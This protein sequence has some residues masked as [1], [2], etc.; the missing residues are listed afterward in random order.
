[1]TLKTMSPNPTP[2]PIKF[3]VARLEEALAQ[4][5]PDALPEIL[6]E[7]ERV[8]AGL[9]IRMLSGT[10]SKEG[11]KPLPPED[12][13]LTPKEA[14]HAL[15]TTPMWV[16]RNSKRLPFTRKLSRKCLRFSELGLRKWMEAQRS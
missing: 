13:L 15:N 11:H 5:S 14:A 9:W 12:R 4:A 3:L 1:M 6:G 16:Y 2:D 8:K 10:P 7:L